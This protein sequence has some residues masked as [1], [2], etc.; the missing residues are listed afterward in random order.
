MLSPKRLSHV[1]RRL[2]RRGDLTGR[3]GMGAGWRSGSGRF[4]V[5]SIGGS[6]MSEL[7]WPVDVELGDRCDRIA[8]QTQRRTEP[9][10]RGKDSNWATV[11][12]VI[13]ERIVWWLSAALRSLTG[14]GSRRTDTRR[15]SRRDCAVRAGGTADSRRRDGVTDT[16]G[17]W[18]GGWRPTAGWLDDR[19][20]R[21]ST[22]ASFVGAGGLSVPGQ[23][24]GVLVAVNRQTLQNREGCQPC[25]QT[26]WLKRYKTGMFA[27]LAN[28][29]KQIREM[30]RWPRGNKFFLFGRSRPSASAST[31]RLCGRQT[32]QNTDVDQ[33]R[34]NL[35]RGEKWAKRD[36][37][38]MLINLINVD[39]PILKKRVLSQ[40]HICRGL[41]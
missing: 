10:R 27:N 8:E 14:G 9:L 11:L 2:Q 20:N 19:D 1:C 7:A 39:H 28:L 3:W 31:M 13:G 23:A 22:T 36:K 34:S 6:E 26:K 4:R 21:L 18:S 15:G 38:G 24:E 40:F 41:P 12:A 16:G 32:L 5:G 30:V 37:T 17:G 29:A 25:Q 35:I 33:C